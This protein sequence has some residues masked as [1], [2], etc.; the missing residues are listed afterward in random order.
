MR[1]CS[2]A[3]HHSARMW[4]NR[5]TSLPA[6]RKILS[7]AGF[8]RQSTKAVPAHVADE[9]SETGVDES[10]GSDNPTGS[11]IGIEDDLQ[12]STEDEREMGEHGHGY[13]NGDARAMAKWIAMHP[14][15][16]EMSP[17]QRFNG[18]AAKVSL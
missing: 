13:T 5:T 12:L 4:R 3:E 10:V 1:P 8:L 17:A 2:K 7:D 16:S 11:S 18:F 15:W 14:K 9:E 6:T